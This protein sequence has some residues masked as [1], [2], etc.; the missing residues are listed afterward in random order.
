MLIL[1]LLP[2]SALPIVPQRNWGKQPSPNLL[3]AQ[4]WAG[5]QEVPSWNWWST[6]G[7]NNDHVTRHVT[8]HVISHLCYGPQTPVGLQSGP[9]SVTHII[10]R[11]WDSL[12]FQFGNTARYN[13]KLLEESCVLYVKRYMMLIP[14][15]QYVNWSTNIF[16]NGII[17]VD[18]ASYNIS[19]SIN[20][21]IQFH[22]CQ[23][24]TDTI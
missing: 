4:N 20:C 13:Y 7:Q 23:S 2:F 18:T 3:P 22:A 9:D 6:I 1:L 19:R 24:N 8:C 11:L 17:L 5:G 16:A 14:A 15:A 21:T 12:A 10:D